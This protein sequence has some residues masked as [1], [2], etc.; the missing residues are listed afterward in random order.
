MA[1]ETGALM[2][3]GL[4]ASLGCTGQDWSRLA[5][6]PSSLQV[7]HLGNAL[8]FP[9]KGLLRGPDGVADLLLVGTITGYL[10]GGEGSLDFPPV[11]GCFHGLS[12]YL[13]LDDLL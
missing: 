7:S 9:V 8:T 12:A 3:Q 5:K 6:D 1:E 2:F 11:S 4:A 10:W 13:F